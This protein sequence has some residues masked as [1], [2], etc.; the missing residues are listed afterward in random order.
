MRRLRSLFAPVVALGLLGVA[1]CEPGV[2][3]EGDEPG[4]EARERTAQ[5]ARPPS[6]TRVDPVAFIA[7]TDGE[8]TITGRGFIPGLSVSV[9]GLAATPPRT[10][11]ATKIQVAIP[12]GLVPGA[13]VAVK[14]TLPDG[15][16]GERTDLLAVLADPMAFTG[17]Q[18]VRKVAVAAPR[19][20]STKRTSGQR[21]TS[22]SIAGNWK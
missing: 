2:L 11:S 10:V 18:P 22:S 15:R 6:L 13:A 20:S 21:F 4:A 7:G 3:P 1:A 5:G 14:V 17:A 12:A 8:L 19:L 9:G 16:S